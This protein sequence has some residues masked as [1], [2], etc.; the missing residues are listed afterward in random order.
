MLLDGD[1]VVLGALG[2]ARE[3]VDDDVGGDEGVAEGVVDGA[4]AVVVE[5][6]AAQPTRGSVA[7]STLATSF[8]QEELGRV[9]HRRRIKR[10]VGVANGGPSP[11]KDLGA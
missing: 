2:L 4:A 6:A 10:F 1:E 8:S 5:R 9:R 7:P 11:S 3:P